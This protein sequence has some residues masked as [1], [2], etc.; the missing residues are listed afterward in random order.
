M[1][2]GEPILLV[3]S[4]RH[5]AAALARELSADG[6]SVALAH[7]CAQTF[8]GLSVNP[9]RLLLL[10]R[11]PGSQAEAII[12]RL[13][14]GA[15]LP[16]ARRGSP[17]VLVLGSEAGGLQ[18]LR[19]FEAGADDFMARPL[20]YLELRAR[21]RALLSRTPPGGDS[22]V[23][24]VGA[25]RIDLR[26]RRVTVEGGALE[27]TRIEF[28]LLAHLARAPG[29]V[30]TRDELLRSVWGFRS[31]GQSRTVDTHAS[32]LRAKLEASSARPSPSWLVSVRGVGYRLI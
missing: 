29:R 14:G 27:L 28:E 16:G 8:E 17:A 10:G 31:A 24:E 23:L 2:A 7:D 30:F 20:S 1:S 19:A 22:E 3:E 9:P 5:F 4:D 21:L 15:E 11:L 13:R 32:R 6:Y 26:A 12:E 18:A 25:L